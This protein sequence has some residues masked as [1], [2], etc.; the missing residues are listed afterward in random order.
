MS[1]EVALN[2]VFGKDGKI[3][4]TPDGTEGPECLE[5]MA[6]IEAINGFHTEE[7]VMHDDA[8]EKFAKIVNNQK[9]GN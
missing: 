6:C 7:T 2:F 8:H 5:L 9:V 3:H 4:L 1:K